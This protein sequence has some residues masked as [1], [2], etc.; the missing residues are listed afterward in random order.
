MQRAP[1]K[2]IMEQPYEYVQQQQQLLHQQQQQFHTNNVLLERSN[3]SQVHSQIHPNHAPTESTSTNSTAGHLQRGSETTAAGE[4]SLPGVVAAPAHDAYA[5]A[6]NGLDA[7]QGRLERKQKYATADSPTPKQRK[8][9]QKNLKRQGRRERHGESRCRQERR[10]SESMTNCSTTSTH[11]AVAPGSKR[12]RPEESTSSTTSNAQ[13]LPSS[14]TYIDTRED[15]EGAVDADD[16]NR[17]RKRE[18]LDHS[19][20]TSSNNSCSNRA[21][22]ITAVAPGENKKVSC[23][24]HLYVVEEPEHGTGRNGNI[25][26]NISLKKEAS[27]L[28][29]L[30]DEW[31]MEPVT[32]LRCAPPGKNVV[33]PTISRVEHAEFAQVHA[34]TILPAYLHLAAGRREE[35]TSSTAFA[36]DVVEPFLKCLRPSCRT[37]FSIQLTEM[38]DIYTDYY[39][40]KLVVEGLANAVDSFHT[41]LKKW[42]KVKA[43]AKGCALLLEHGICLTVRLDKSSPVGAALTNL[44]NPRDLRRAFVLGLSVKHKP[45]GQ[46]AKI[47]GPNATA[48]GAAILSVDGKP[49]YSIDAYKQTVKESEGTD[50]ILVLC[51]DRHADLSGLQDSLLHLPPWL[52][53]G[54]PLD[55]N[56]E[57]RAPPAADGTA[58]QGSKPALEEID[59]AFAQTVFQ[60]SVVQGPN[61]VARL[62][63]Q[64]RCVKASRD[65][66]R[67]T[68]AARRRRRRRRLER[69]RVLH[70]PSLEKELPE[71][72]H[73]SFR[74]PKKEESLEVPPTPSLPISSSRLSPTMGWPSVDSP[75]ASLPELTGDEKVVAYKFFQSK[76]QNVVYVEYSGSGIKPNMAI[77]QMWRHH[78]IQHGPKCS[79][80]CNCVFDLPYLTATVLDTKIKAERKK[81]KSNWLKEHIDGGNKFPTGFVD[82]F[83]PKFLPML[84]AKF[85]H[86]SPQQLLHR[87]LGMWQKHLR[88][89]NFGLQCNDTCDCMEG[90]SQV[91]REGR[92]L[93]QTPTEIV[94]SH[95]TNKKMPDP[96]EQ[97]KSEL[98][99]S[100]LDSREN[101][102]SG[103]KNSPRVPK[104][105]KSQAI[106][107]L[108][109]GLIPPSQIVNG[110]SRTDESGVRSLNLSNRVPKKKKNAAPTLSQPELHTTESG[111]LLRGLLKQEAPPSQT[112]NDYESSTYG[113][114]IH[115]ANLSNRVPK[116]KNADATSSDPHLHT[117][118]SGSLLWGLPNKQEA[119][120]SQTANNDESRTFRNGMHSAN[121]SN[122]VPKKSINAH[123]TSSEP[124]VHA[125]G[126]GSLLRGLLKPDLSKPDP[127]SS[128]K[129]KKA[130][131]AL[132]ALGN[133]E[134]KVGHGGHKGQSSAL[135]AASEIVRSSNPPPSN[136]VRND[137]RME[138]TTSGDTWVTVDTKR[139]IRVED[140]PK[141]ILKNIERGGSNARKRKVQFG[142][143]PINECRFYEIDGKTTEFQMKSSEGVNKGTQALSA[144]SNKDLS[145][146]NNQDETLQVSDSQTSLSDTIQ[147]KSFK[148]V[149]AFFENTKDSGAQLSE[150][151]KEAL[152]IVKD[153]RLSINAELALNPRD[154]ALRRRS[155]DFEFKNSFLKI[156]INAAYALQFAR[157]LKNWVRFEIMV[158]MIDEIELSDHARV[159]GGENTLSAEVTATYV[160]R[161]NR[162]FCVALLDT[163]AR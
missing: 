138:S 11:A 7:K 9:H 56:A 1:A 148:D 17:L 105:R 128:K 30:P 66:E 93:T 29:W 78:K 6:T 117:T 123:A 65:D 90:W 35:L 36:K 96:R 40:W 60:S 137:S 18:K 33:D 45:N 77:G 144:G 92:D 98:T 160:S 150:R 71:Q 121:D 5:L 13:T 59:A 153:Y 100:S 42:I 136:G 107:S 132:L 157:S 47:I 127:T 55:L 34:T 2:C 41:H 143:N 94:A 112:A 61:D 68:T 97:S 39:W 50:T 162:C 91:F 43:E 85:P 32:R 115:S 152:Q 82:S 64:Y 135:R 155:R 101:E 38:C 31:C 46:L 89:R 156:C 58:L 70:A 129:A 10:K 140:L 22:A 109:S 49:C 88:Q 139:A 154:E 149:L 95:S 76:Y 106:S 3:Q 116:K 126:S 20:G 87:L 122:R 27:S 125:T 75:S 103:D 4:G 130:K 14:S 73:S 158:T 19:T 141:P 110:E 108:I 79:D 131:K 142:A 81:P 161:I 83:A 44:R 25:K 113:S 67:Q 53:D 120:P 99:F 80:N 111:S 86:E 104:K 12:P 16:I 145:S 8:K 63:F 37:G 134:I 21:A 146:L 57:R 84:K 147:D 102:D 28:S 62:V 48:L 133:T 119:P 23:V 118:E 159:E 114:G 74:I 26:M 124:D 15:R 54:E 52:L 24:K 163:D 69:V 72:P 51:V 151:L